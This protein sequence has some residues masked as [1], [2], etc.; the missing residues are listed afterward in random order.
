MSRRFQSFL[1]E[2]VCFKHHTG[3]IWFDLCHIRTITVHCGLTHERATGDVSNPVGSAVGY[4]VVFH[5]PLMTSHDYLIH[6]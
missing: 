2:I 1:D 4:E 3:E 6:K 5:I